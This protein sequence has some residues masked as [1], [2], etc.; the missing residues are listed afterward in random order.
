MITAN[1]HD[2]KTNLSKLLES[3]MHGQ[4]VVIKKFNKPIAR[5]IIYQDIPLHKRTAGLLKGKISIKKCFN[6]DSPEVE[7]M[8][9]N[10]VI[11]PK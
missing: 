11:F 9:A 5:I 8:F 1:I 6:D 3:V 7:Q 10:S 4:D 2:A